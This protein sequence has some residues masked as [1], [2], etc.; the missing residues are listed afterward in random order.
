MSRLCGTFSALQKAVGICA[1]SGWADAESKLRRDVWWWRRRRRKR[2]S[3]LARWRRPPVTEKSWNW[4]SAARA[5]S[6]ARN[7]SSEWPIRHATLK[8]FLAQLWFWVCCCATEADTRPGQEEQPTAFGG[9]WRF[10]P[11]FISS[12]FSRQWGPVPTACSYNE[13]QPKA[14]K[15]IFVWSPPAPPPARSLPNT[16]NAPWGSL[17]CVF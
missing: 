11:P 14:P 4:F 8:V 5:L 7:T 2:I 12:Q 10:S 9:D 15:L 17:F 3:T 16:Q 13:R 1:R 6:V